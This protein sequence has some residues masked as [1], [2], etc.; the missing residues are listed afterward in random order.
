MLRCAF[1][2]TTE[3]TDLSWDEVR[4]DPYAQVA[5]VSILA[6]KTSK[7]KSFALPAGRA[8]L[9]CVY[10]KAGD[11]LST[12]HE[13]RGVYDAQSQDARVFPNLSSKRF[14][15]VPPLF[16]PHYACTLAS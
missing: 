9:D 12:S 14:P 7:A 10:L 11:W 15:G 13:A 1:G 2:R 3:V 16:H 6:M 5:T 8:C 4:W